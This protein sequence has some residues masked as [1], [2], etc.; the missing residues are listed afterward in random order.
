MRGQGT[1]RLC[2]KD[3][4]R[5][6]NSEVKVDLTKNEVLFLVMGEYQNPP[7]ENEQAPLANS[8]NKKQKK[9]VFRGKAWVCHLFQV[10]VKFAND[11]VNLSSF[12]VNTNVTL[13]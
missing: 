2:H 9:S 11:S 4:N 5:R 10:A 13:Q 7:S 6:E 12:I 1:T 3:E 8:S